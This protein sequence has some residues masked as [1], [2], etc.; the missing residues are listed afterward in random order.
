MKILVKLPLIGRA[1][2]GL[3]EALIYF[4]ALVINEFSKK[5]DN[6]VVITYLRGL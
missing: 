6:F 3:I 5:F 1:D 4:N 2:N